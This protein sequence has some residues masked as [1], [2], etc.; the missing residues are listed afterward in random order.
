MRAKTIKKN[1]DTIQFESRTEIREIMEIINKYVKQNPAEKKNKILER[2]IC[3]TLWIW[4]GKEN[5]SR[6]AD[7]RE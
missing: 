7:W 4:N 5:S 3:L 1:M 6:M 2:L